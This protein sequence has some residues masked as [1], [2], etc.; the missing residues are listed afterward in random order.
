MKRRYRMLGLIVGLAVTALFV[1][2][3]IRALHGHDLRIYETPRAV[4]GIVFAALLW[5]ACLPLIGLAWHGLLAGLQ[6]HR[7]RRELTA[8][9]GITQIAKYIPGN[10]AQYLGR[11]GLSLSRGIPARPLA[12]TLTAEVM[13]VICAAMAVGFGAGIWSMVGLTVLNRH[14][15]QLALVVVAL[16]GVIFFLIACLRFAPALLRR[17]KPKHAHLFEGALLPSRR[18]M[19]RAFVLYLC[20]YACLGLSLVILAHW[21][22]PDAKQDNWLLIASFSLAWV[23][24]FATP[25]APAGL[26]VREGLLLIMLAPVY[27][28][29]AASVLVVALRLATTL[30]DVIGC[31]GGLLVLPKARLVDARRTPPLNQ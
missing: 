11:A 23:V 16:L 10:V 9:L 14:R 27:S 5:T 17:F 29:A 26:G 30:G 31:A 12:A 6:V 19:L 22:L 3:V 2:Y 24:G 15:W 18:E 28:S 4:A 7:S 13:L 21:L 8:I 1:L 20:V 25:G